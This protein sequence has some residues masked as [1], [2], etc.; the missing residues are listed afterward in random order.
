MKEGVY[1][2]ADNPDESEQWEEEKKATTARSE[3]E[4]GGDNQAD[5]DPEETKKWE[6]DKEK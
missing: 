5:D 4:P 6:K 2:M 1:Q 3:A